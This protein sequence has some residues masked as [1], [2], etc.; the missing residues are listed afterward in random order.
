[1]PAADPLPTQPV[2]ED[3]PRVRFAKRELM[4]VLVALEE[5]SG[6][7]LDMGI[8]V[9]RLEDDLADAREDARRWRRG[10]EAAKQLLEQTTSV[11]A[12]EQVERLDEAVRAWVGKS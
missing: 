2:V 5:V 9:L 8:R 7:D 1:M 6:S 3:S 4:R 10:Y 12:E 11:A